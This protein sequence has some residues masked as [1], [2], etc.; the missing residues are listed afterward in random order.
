M[1][2]PYLVTDPGSRLGLGA[3]SRGAQAYLMPVKGHPAAICCWL[4][5]E[6]FSILD[7]RR[8]SAES[9]LQAGARD[10]ED[11]DAGAEARSRPERA[12]S[13]SP[14]LRRCSCDQLGLD[15]GYAGP[16]IAGVEAAGR[17]K[18]FM[19]CCGAT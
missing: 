5:P 17:G 7:Q 10:P 8:L 15:C 3:C 2:A 16:T 19:K 4:I 1:T 13:R 18:V 14:Q 12:A 9:A 11:R 6:N